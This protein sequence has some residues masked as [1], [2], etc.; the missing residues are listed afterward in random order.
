M[1]EFVNEEGK[2]IDWS[3]MGIFLS[4]PPNATSNPVSIRIQCFL[5]GPD[6]VILQENTELV[7]PIYDITISSD[8]TKMA[9]LS[10]A[11]FAALHSDIECLDME[12]LHSTDRSPPYHF[13]PVPGGKFLPH[14]ALGTITVNMFSKWAIGKRKRTASDRCESAP[15]AP[16]RHKEG[17]QKQTG[18]DQS[19]KQTQG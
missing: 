1:L 17:K 18:S 16:K 11:H 10:V 2:T 12:F 3:D 5:P 13:Y 15:L 4:I 6:S 14:G 8:L 9:M 7:S 19:T